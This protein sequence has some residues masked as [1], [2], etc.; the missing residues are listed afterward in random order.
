[1]IADSI[2]GHQVDQLALVRRGMDWEEVE[3][4]LSLGYKGH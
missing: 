4:I 1:M 2:F 3:D